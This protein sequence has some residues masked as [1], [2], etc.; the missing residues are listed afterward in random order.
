MKVVHSLFVSFAILGIGLALPVA[1]ADKTEITER[2]I[3]HFEAPLPAGSRLRIHVRSGDIRIVGSDDAKLSVDLSGQKS[4][5]I[6][7][8]RYRLTSKD[9]VTEF[10]LSGGPKNDLVITIHVPKNSELYLRVP[11][12][13]VTVEGVTGSKD[14]ELHAGDLTIE[15]GSPSDYSSVDTSVSA[16]DIDGGPFGESHGGLFRSM[17]KSGTGKYT[18]H[19]HVGAGDL[20]LR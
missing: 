20:T 10:S 16:G 3:P 15:V 1:G 14:V 5:Q 4:N 19:A 8:V 9:S 13:D 7:D 12:G 11:A 18:L 6:E 2:G 17:K